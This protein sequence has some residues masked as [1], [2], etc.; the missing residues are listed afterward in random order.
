VK[1]LIDCQYWKEYQGMNGWL[2]FCSAG[3]FAKKFEVD[4]AEKIGCTAEQRAVCK[5]TMEINMG[6]S[7]LPE[8]VEADASQKKEKVKDAVTAPGKSA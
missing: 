1:K 2:M 3:A 5:K 6:Y 8:I 7:L 4:E